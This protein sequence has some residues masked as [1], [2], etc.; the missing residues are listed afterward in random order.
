MSNI[1]LSIV[2]VS[3]NNLS[4]L[5]DCINSIYKFN[6]IGEELEVI[7]V[8]NSNNL[9]TYD[10][11]KAKYDDIIIIKNK[12]N[13][14][15]EG[16]NVGARI[17]KGDYIVFLNPDTVLI[18]PVF[19]FA[20]EKFET[21]S[22][23]SLFGVKLLDSNLKSN[24]SFYFIDRHSFI[25]GQT[26]KILNKINFFLP[27]A[28]FISGAN[29]FVRRDVFIEAGMFD[30]KIFMYY[31]ESDLIK[32]IKSLGGKIKFY[33]DKKIIHLEGKTVE[34][35]DAALYRRLDS[36]QYYCN[37]YSL[38][39]NKQIKAEIRYNKLKHFIYRLTNNINSTNTNNVI[40]ILNEY[41]GKKHDKS[42]NSV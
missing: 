22:N 3:Y 13:G 6:D 7:I 38:N 29:L 21:N 24:L 26:T 28:M 31:E 19:K 8:D 12:N 15:G 30:E 37:K 2:I 10:Y 4:V 18:E 41:G 35:N 1:K 25:I 39:F 42:N 40:N 14:F 33:K 16:N 27:N 32:R 17:A 34:N 9:N 11:I 36:A 5:I 20:I 23:L